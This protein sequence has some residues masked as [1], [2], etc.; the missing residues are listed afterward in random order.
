MKVAVILNPVAG[1]RRA[2]GCGETLRGRLLSAGHL[3]TIQVTRQAGDA[4]KFAAD[5]ACEPADL[6]VAVGGDGTLCEVLNG[7]MA[8]ARR[9]KLGLIPL[10]TGNDFARCTGIPL[11]VAGAI[12]TLLSGTSRKVDVGRVEFDDGTSR[13]FLNVA[14]CGFDALAAQRVNDNRKRPLWRHGKGTPAFMLAIVQEISRLRAATLQFNDEEP[15]RALLCAIANTAS[16]GGGMRVAPDATI[17][18]GLFDVCIIAEASRI[19]FLRAFPQVF[20]GQH[21]TH[22]KV[23]LHRAKQFSLTSNPSLPVLVDGDVQGFTPARFS[24]EAMAVEVMVP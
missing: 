16:Y 15:R 19:E 2:V 20:S 18:D 3:V 10:G 12:Q 23:S 6:V 7:L 11:D 13:H 22:P 14:G 21:L 17:D 4:E 1:R 8:A 24:L 9:P 5:A